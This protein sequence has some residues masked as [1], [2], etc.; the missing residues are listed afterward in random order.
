MKNNFNKNL[1]RFSIRKKIIAALSINFLFMIGLGVYVI[2]QFA[3]IS[4]EHDKVQVLNDKVLDQVNAVEKL[5]L[6][7]TL[8]YACASDL[9]QNKFQDLSTEINKCLKHSEEE[10]NLSLSKSESD[11]EKQSY[12]SMLSSISLIWNSEE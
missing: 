5:H 7:Q 9:D 10:L 2:K 4:A 8:S 6:K 11:S 12:L 3:S 1:L